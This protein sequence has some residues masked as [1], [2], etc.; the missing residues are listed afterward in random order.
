M[1]EHESRPRESVGAG[2]GLALVKELVGA[3]DG[4]VSVQ[5]KSGRGSCFSVVLRQTSR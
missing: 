2:V 5:S 1:G 3:M 4:S